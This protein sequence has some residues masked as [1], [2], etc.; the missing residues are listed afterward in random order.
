MAKP[1][2]G[3]PSLAVPTNDN[4]GSVTHVEANCKLNS[5]VQRCVLVSG[6]WSVSIKN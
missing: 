4:W 6:E 1:V 5:V 3:K 2:N